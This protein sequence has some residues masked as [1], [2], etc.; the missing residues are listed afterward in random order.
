MWHAPSVI[1]YSCQ[2]GCGAFLKCQLAV[3]T[4]TRDFIDTTP[5]RETSPRYSDFIGGTRCGTRIAGMQLV[6]VANVYTI[7]YIYIYIY[8]FYFNF[9][10]LNR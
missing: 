9:F 10:F 2:T 7:Y 3:N 5:W 1:C 4:I 8:I 6:L